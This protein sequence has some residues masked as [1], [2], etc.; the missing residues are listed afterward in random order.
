[1]S[2]PPYTPVF[3]TPGARAAK[4]LKFRLITGRASISAV[5]TIRVS[6]LLLV[7]SRGS[8]PPTMT[9]ST[10]PRELQLEVDCHRRAHVECLGLARAR[11]K[12]VELC[13]YGIRTRPK[14]EE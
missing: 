8:V 10:T 12:A 6:V 7:S 5:C 14:I 2:T 13:A 4:S 3:V 1:M 9:C 11:S